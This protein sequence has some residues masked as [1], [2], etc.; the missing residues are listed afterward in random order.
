MYCATSATSP[1]DH[2][3]DCND[4]CQEQETSDVS[5]NAKTSMIDI[6]SQV[7]KHEPD[8]HGKYDHLLLIHKIGS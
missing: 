6:L 5:H 2:L 1:F 3:F 4:A 8:D 7:S